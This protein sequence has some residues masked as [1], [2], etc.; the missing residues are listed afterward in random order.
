MAE[1]LLGTS[2]DRSWNT[3]KFIYRYKFLIIEFIY[4]SGAVS[5]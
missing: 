3:L 5:P 1:N 2:L 4:S